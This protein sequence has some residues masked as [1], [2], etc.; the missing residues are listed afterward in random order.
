MYHIIKS[1]F[2]PLLLPGVDLVALWNCYHHLG[3][4]VKG[5]P[6]I[7][8]S[9]LMLRNERIIQTLISVFFCLCCSFVSY[10]VIHETI[11]SISALVPFIF[12][13]PPTKNLLGC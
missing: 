4:W 10:L 6:A 13:L 8:S 5:T 7:F 3:V 12:Q 11:V 1:A 2:H 9:D